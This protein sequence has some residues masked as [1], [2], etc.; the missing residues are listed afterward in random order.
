MGHTYI[1][2]K[3]IN[4]LMRY[5]GIVENSNSYLLPW[6][7]PK[8]QIT[9]LVPHQAL[10]IMSGPDLY[11][12]MLLNEWVWIRVPRL[13]LLWDACVHAKS[14]QSCPTLCDPTRLLCPW[15]SAGKNTGVCCH[16]H[17]QG[18]LPIQGS[19]PCFLCLLYC[20]W[21]LYLWATR[22]APSFVG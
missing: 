9:C 8:P 11:T 19:N 3:F 16:A 2:E 13:Y 4:S 12:Q 7:L 10:S 18:I 22:E 17:L 21:I 15:D 20:R 6:F 14:L 5:V 1:F